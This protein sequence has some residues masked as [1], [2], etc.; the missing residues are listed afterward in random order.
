[1]ITV[2]RQPPSLLQGWETPN[3]RPRVERVSPDFAQLHGLFSFRWRL[4]L[5][6]GGEAELSS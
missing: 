2:Y 4:G 6:R 5:R 1:M 3:G